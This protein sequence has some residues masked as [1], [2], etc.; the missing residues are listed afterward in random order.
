[1]EWAVYRFSMDPS[2]VTVGT[3][4]EQCLVAVLPLEGQMLT[5]RLQVRVLLGE[6]LW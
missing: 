6:P 5:V 4:P 2:V 1:M 3:L